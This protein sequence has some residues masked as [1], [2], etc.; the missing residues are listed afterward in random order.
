[1]VRNSKK[2]RR[3]VV[4]G[5]TFLWSLRHAHQVEEGQFF[6]CREILTISLFGAGGRLRI[7]F[8][9]GAGRVV[10]DGFAPSG[11]VGV[12]GGGWLNLHEPGTVRA[13]L[14]E[15][16]SSGWQ[17]SDPSSEQMDGWALFDVV[18]SRRVLA[19]PD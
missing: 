16:V 8:R 3:L 18:A 11:S 15:A 19:P 6:E 10:P 2:A 17:P 7:V 4:D 13:L 14:D 12:V 5:E 1:M 9:E